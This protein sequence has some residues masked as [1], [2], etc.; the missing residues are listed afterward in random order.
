MKTTTLV[1]KT[2]PDE[3]P[4]FSR[5]IEPGL[6]IYEVGSLVEDFAVFELSGFEEGVELK[7]IRWM[8]EQTDGLE[9]DVKILRAIEGWRMRMRREF[10]KWGRKD[11]PD[12]WDYI[13]VNLRT[14]CDTTNPSA[15]WREI[16]VLFL[17]RC[18]L[19][20]SRLRGC[21]QKPKV[22]LGRGKRESAWTREYVWIFDPLNQEIEWN[23]KK[24]VSFKKVPSDV[25]EYLCQYWLRR[26]DDPSL[27][28]IWDEGYQGRYLNN[29]RF[30]K[31]NGKEN[32]IPDSRSLNGFLIEKWKS[33][34]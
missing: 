33:T 15:K 16:P 28:P 13:P 32:W 23:T 7:S 34:P 24:A 11:A 19:W 26:L 22:P 14:W 3:K 17:W 31:W 8:Q 12:C 27:S 10:L 30:E 1:M 25:G 9:D 20:L 5:K 29:L 2:N 21:Q 6:E 18:H 4:P